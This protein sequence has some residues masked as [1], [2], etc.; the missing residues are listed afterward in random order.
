MKE[1]SIQ[2]I[3]D[4]LAH[5]PIGRIVTVVPAGADDYVVSIED[6]RHRR[7]HVLETP[8]DFEAWLDSFKQGRLLRLTKALCDCCCKVHSDRDIDGELFELC[9][10]CQAELTAVIVEN[11][12]P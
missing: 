1:R 9:L 8:G 12:S 2:A 3:A 5:R 11:A 6:R 7:E 4:H 10:A